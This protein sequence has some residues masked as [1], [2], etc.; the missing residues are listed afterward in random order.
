MSS[1]AREIALLGGAPIELYRFTR[2][3]VQWYYAST[4][5]QARQDVVFLAET[6]IAAAIAQSKIVVGGDSQQQTTTI[7]LPKDLP[8]AANWRPYP[9]GDPLS[10]TKWRWHWQEG[11]FLVDWIGNLYGPVYDDTTLQLK[12]D[13]TAALSKTAGRQRVSQRG[14]DLVLFSAGR[15][16]CNVDKAAHAVAAT[17][18]AVDAG[19]LTLTAAAFSGVPS[20][21]LAGGWIEWPRA[22]GIVEARDITAHAGATVTLA[23]GA[24]DLA[25]GLTVTAYPGC[26]GSWGDCEYFGNTANFGGE[27]YKPGRNYYSGN[28][29]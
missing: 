13:S 11:D 25:A 3:G 4:A 15:G 12:S 18:T 8:V 27:P 9:P 22:D 2:G 28:L 16:Q 20:G 19:T 1:A 26:N 21:R 14:C 10:V 29:I 5:G 7:T 6:Y 17:V 24:L 23:Y